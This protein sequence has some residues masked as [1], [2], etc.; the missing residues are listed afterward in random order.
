MCKVDKIAATF[1]RDENS[2]KKELFFNNAKKNPIE[3]I[4]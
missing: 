3:Q 2:W 1:V 4:S